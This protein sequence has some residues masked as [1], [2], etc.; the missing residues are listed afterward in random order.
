MKVSLGEKKI[1]MGK[2][3]VALVGREDGSVEIFLPESKAMREVPLYLKFVAGC[4]TLCADPDFVEL[5]C[6]LVEE[7]ISKF[8]KERGN[9][10]LH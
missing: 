4:G 10:T 6:R 9:I 8:Q 7:R 2:K 3:D 1:G 5:V